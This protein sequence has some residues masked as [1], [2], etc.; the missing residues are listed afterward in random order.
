MSAFE[1]NLSREIRKDL[2][3]IYRQDNIHVGLL[4]DMIRTG[5]KPYD[6]YFLYKSIFVSIEFKLI[7]TGYT[8]N[9]V[10]HIKTHQPGCLKNVEKA[11]GVGV[12]LIGFNVERTVLIVR[13]QVVIDILATGQESIKY[14]DLHDYSGV[15]KMYRRRINNETRWGVEDLIDAIKRFRS[16]SSV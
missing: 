1:A 6:A 16:E 14:Q 4:P 13:P 12:F 3:N 5:V 7:K 11:G 15:A 8:I 10:N 2:E 9:L